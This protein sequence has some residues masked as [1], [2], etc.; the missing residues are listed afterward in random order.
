MSSL[1][2][3]CLSFS[4][5]TK[6]IFNATSHRLPPL[7]KFYL[8]RKL[9][10][11]QWH[12][13][14]Y[15]FRIRSVELISFVKNNVEQFYWTPTIFTLHFR[16]SFLILDVEM[17]QLRLSRSSAKRCPKCHREITE[18]LNFHLIYIRKEHNE[19]W[20]Q[21]YLSSVNIYWTVN[22]AI[23]K[24]LGL[25]FYQITLIS[26]NTLGEILRFSVSKYSR[27]VVMSIFAVT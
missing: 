12:P 5:V 25:T 20:R 1:K 4:F 24:C 10:F 18:L 15:V 22:W 19:W 7:R 2:K 17:R 6:W 14:R 21:R 26:I 13:V 16:F 3:F 9:K 23:C 8:S 27:Y 11:G